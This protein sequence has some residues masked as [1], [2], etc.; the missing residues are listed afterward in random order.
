MAAAEGATSASSPASPAP[1]DPSIAIGAPTD[2]AAV[3]GPIA[4][5]ASLQGASPAQYYMFWEVGSG[6]YNLMSTAGSGKSVTVD[7]SGWNWEPSGDYQITFIAQNLQGQEIARRSITIHV[8]VPAS[9]ALPSDVPSTEIGSTAVMAAAPVA[10]SPSSAAPSAA[11]GDVFNGAKLYVDPNSLAAQAQR[12][13]ADSDPYDASLL[14]K[15]AGQPTAAWFGGWNTNVKDDVNTVV[16]AAAQQGAIPVLVA[17]NI[18]DRDCGGYSAGGAET[19]DA[20]AQWIAQFAAGIGGRRA[21]VILEPD[22]LALTNCLSA[23]ELQQRFAML[24]GAVKT[25]T[26]AGASVY[27]DAGH[28]DWVDPVTMAANLKAA[29]IAD[30]AGF[31]L[32]VSN[33]YPTS[34]NEAYGAQVSALAGGAHFV[35]DTSRNGNGSQGGEWCNPQGAAVGQAP[36]AATG[37][38]LADAFLWLK[39]PGESDG[40][41]NGGPS[42]GTFWTGYALQLLHNA[43]F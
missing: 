43:G 40:T 32:N 21:T 31:A 42:A 24:T 14:G 30:A 27:L 5:S 10:A 39:P 11:G 8:G 3:N 36:T 29:D 4:F 22:S 37:D 19:S 23:S 25:L 2:G 16:T 34:A 38:P 9:Q 6:Q 17:Y 41:C 20:Y 33:F 28:A 7:P 15:I 1:A 12:A 35:I 13:L 26:A 18:P